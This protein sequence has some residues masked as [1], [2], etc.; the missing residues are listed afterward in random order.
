MTLSDYGNK[1]RANKHDE[2]RDSNVTSWPDIY[3][4]KK[5]CFLVSRP[6]IEFKTS[7]H[8]FTDKSHQNK[9]GF[10]GKKLSGTDF[11]AFQQNVCQT[12]AYSAN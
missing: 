11:T 7:K 4:R 8:E 3:F 1:V 2:F 12:M 6:N 5:F 10:E 9:Q